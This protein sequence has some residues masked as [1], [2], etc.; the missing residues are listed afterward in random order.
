MTRK[1]FLLLPPSEAKA[2]GGS[3]GT[4]VGEFDHHLDGARRHVIEALAALRATQSS[5]ALEKVLKVRGPLLQRAVNA[6]GHL[7]DGDALL[8]PAWRR[9]VGVVW[10]HLDAATMPPAHRRRLLIPSGLYGVTTG[11]DHIADYRLKMDATLPLLGGVAHYWRPH[12]TSA[13]A[14][15][16]EGSAVINLLPKEHQSS[17]DWATL[18]QGCQVVNVSFVR[19]DGRG[20][21]G[22]A[23]KAVKGIV[24]RAIVD[25][26]LAAM[27]GFR[28]QGWRA[29]RSEEGILIVAPPAP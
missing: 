3:K 18:D 21:A 29:R 7:E 4:K 25:E 9:Y 22:H 27:D 28:W 2:E 24:A 6:I 5:A 10:L 1:P 11:G 20:A 17:I 23:A 16:V 12:V 19:A 8:M 26:G 15:H 14:A 13:M